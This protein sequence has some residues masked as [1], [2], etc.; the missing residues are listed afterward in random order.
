MFSQPFRIS[1]PNG[2]QE[3]VNRRVYR[4][5]VIRG[6]CGEDS[7]FVVDSEAPSSECRPPQTKYFHSLQSSTLSAHSGLPT[8][9][10][11]QQISQLYVPCL[12]PASQIAFMSSVILRSYFRRYFQDVRELDQPNVYGRQLHALDANPSSHSDNPR[13]AT[14]YQQ[15]PPIFCRSSFVHSMKPCNLG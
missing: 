10:P 13:P 11:K 9:T 3:T 8:V 12:L 2:R 5:V 4:L 15:H 7:R 6:N 1:S 14:H